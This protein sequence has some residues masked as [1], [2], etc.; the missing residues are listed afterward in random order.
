MIERVV[1]P[2]DADYQS[3]L[4][5]YQGTDSFHRLEEGQYF[6]PGFVDLHV[7]AR[8]GLNPEPHWTFR[9]TIG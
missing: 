6:L 8:N 9:S 7:H 1:A 2:E 5:T 3:L 4:D